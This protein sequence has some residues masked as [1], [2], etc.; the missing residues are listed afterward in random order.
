MSQ[1][2]DRFADL[3]PAG[4]LDQKRGEFWIANPWKVFRSRRNLSAFEPNQVFLN[5]GPGRFAD[6]GY[7]TGADSDGDGRGVLVADVDGDLQPDLLVRQSG[8]GPLRVYANR[9]PPASRLVVTLSGT[10]SNRLGIGATVVAEVG[11]RRI[12]RQLF[13]TNNFIV[14]QASQVSFGLG[15]A[16]KVDRLTVHWPSGEVQVLHDVP[17]GVHLR[18]QEGRSEPEVLLRAG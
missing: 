4:E 18:I 9:F 13:P 17:V 12:S 6:V 16:K 3:A 1:P 8:G 7:L 15:R 14:Q 10:K 5:L 11:G 2:T